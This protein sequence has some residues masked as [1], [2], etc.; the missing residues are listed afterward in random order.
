MATN[1]LKNTIL[2][3]QV[4]PSNLKKAIKVRV[5]YFSWNEYFKAYYKQESDF[6]VHDPADD[7]QV[8]DTVVIKTLEKQW[9]KDIT[10]QVSTFLF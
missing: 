3:G 10:H 8:G 9:K 6:V 7:C 4:I 5:P 1:I 2:L